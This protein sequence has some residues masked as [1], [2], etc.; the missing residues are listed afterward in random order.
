MKRTPRQAARAET[1]RLKHM[2][3]FERELWSAG[4]IHVAGVDEVGVGPLAGPVVA[5]AAI[6]PVGRS[7]LGINDSKKLT[8]KQREALAAELREHATAWALGSASEAE[9][10]HINILQASRLAMKRAVEA[11]ALQ[12]QH[13]L[14]DARD[15]DLPLP[16]T[17]I[18]KGDALSQSIAAASILAK[19]HRDA[20]MDHY[21]KTYPDYGFEMHRGYPT[22]KHLAALMKLGP[23]PIHRRSY[24]PVK[25]ALRPRQDLLPG[26]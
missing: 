23:C 19:V 4:L 11:L 7:F 21:A 15:I 10:D 6:L 24:A 18:I 12:P 5:A 20:L 9:I 1:K 14:I 8:E 26:V 25:K 13:L 17:G 2:L 3:R 16:Q 22:P